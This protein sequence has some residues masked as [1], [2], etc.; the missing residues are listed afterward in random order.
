MPIDDIR[1]HYARGFSPRWTGNVNLVMFSGDVQRF[2]AG[3][4]L[5]IVKKQE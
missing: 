5:V 3:Q 2:C 4:K 1:I